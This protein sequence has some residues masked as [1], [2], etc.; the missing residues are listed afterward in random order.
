MRLACGFALLAPA[1]ASA[2]TRE[3]LEPHDLWTAWQFAPGV[4]LPLALTALLY[5]RGARSSRGVSASQA[6][7]FWSGWTVLTLALISPLHSLGEVLFSAHMLQHELLILVAAPLLVLSRPLVPMLWG[8]PF[9][10]RRTAGRWSKVPPVEG[11]WRGLTAP[12]AAWLLHAIALWAWHAP[13]MFQATLTS[14][15]AHTAQHLSFLGTALLFWWSLFYTHG[16]L[17]YGASFLY[18]F[19]TSVHTSILGALLTF[20]PSTWYPA[21][22]VRTAAWGISPLADQQIGGLVMWIP[23]GIVYLGLALLLFARWLR[24]SETLAAGRWYAR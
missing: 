11:P 19:T 16:R 17:G 22:G 23:A 2:H 14:E 13:A 15:W 12:P 24:E 18:V 4:L 3:P 10:W 6:A 21:Y 20:A 8:L 7:F 5:A 9:Q 1:V